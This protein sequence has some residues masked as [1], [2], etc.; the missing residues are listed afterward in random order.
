MAIRRFNAPLLAYVSPLWY[1]DDYEKAL[2]ANEQHQQPRN[3]GSS[4]A[5][6]SSSSSSSRV[7]ESRKQQALLQSPRAL[8]LD[9]WETVL[10]Y[11]RNIS[12]VLGASK[13]SSGA[14]MTQS[15][16]STRDMEMPSILRAIWDL[17]EIFYV[18]KH[19]S[20]W[21]PEQLINWLERYDK[22][23]A[24]LGP[25]IHCKLAVLQPRLV[26]T[27]FPED[28]E[29]YWSGLTSA[30]AVGWLDVVVKCLRMHGSYQH[31][32]IDNRQTENG[33]VEAVVVLITKM[34][35]LRPNPKLD[36]LGV[37]Y[38]FK[39]EFSKA[40]ERWRNQIAK[41]NSSSFWLECT[42]EGTVNG[43]KQLLSV[44]LGD[45]NTLTAATM[46]W[47][48]LLVSHFLFIRP[49]LMGAEG[50]LSLARKCV[51]LKLPAEADQMLDLLLAILGEDTEVVLVEC[52]KLFDPWMLTHMVELLLAKNGQ[53][54]LFLTEERE[55]L[56]GM[57]LEE[58]HRLVYAQLLSSHPCTWQ[59]APFYL[60][61]CP[62][63]GQGLLEAVLLMQPVSSHS[64]A[65]M[66]VLDICRMYEL[67]SV[68]D[69]YMRMVGVYHWKHGRKGL[70]ISWL[71]CGRDY[72]RLS[73]AA[74]ELLAAVSQTSAGDSNRLQEL[75]GLIDLLGPQFEGFGGLAFLHRFRDFKVSLYSFQEAQTNLAG[76]DKQ[77]VAGKAATKH[78]IQLMKDG[79]TPQRF[80]LPLLQDSVEL[81]EYSGEVL[82]TAAETN[83]LLLKL[84]NFFL[85]NKHDDI[86]STEIMSQSV[87]KIRLALA[88]NLG[89]AI[90]KE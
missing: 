50:L 18:D 69:K 17:L 30:L 78:L 67:R 36:T 85:T 12:A 7:V 49:F 62:R 3:A 83:A 66:K 2:K 48:E 44:L 20:S 4:A 19:A 90:L 27:R 6:A 84:Q 51:Q 81:L 34:P 16:K 70:G 25:T 72:E 14:S 64:K 28:D 73:C 26:N 87:A 1:I 56:D 41:L 35:R 89:R 63:Q 53:A 10:D 9:W 76:I 22:V 21:L 8:P 60:A 77:V 5:A 37:T 47:M 43:L 45:V 38:T 23:L 88:C 75:D 61:S 24:I 58:F 71:Q 31:D 40:W 79:I 46:H 74:D 54:Q 29:D 42:H 55:V 82:V 33:L 39:P 52:R 65:P 68:G 13:S 80:L 15:T 32:Q 57:S 59:L 11:S 86:N